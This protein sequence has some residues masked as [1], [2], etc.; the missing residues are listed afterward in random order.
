MLR[1]IIEKE[2]RDLAGSP[3]FILTFAVCATLIVLSFFIGAANY[4]ASVERYNAANA[5]NLR[6]YDG[7][8]DWLDVRD[9]R[10]FLAPQPLEALVA[11]ISNDIGRTTDVEARGELAAHGSRYNEEPILAVFRFLDLEF[12]FLIVLSLF[13]IL[14][15]YD[16]VSG[17]KERGTLRLVLSN[18]VPRSKY[19]LGKLLGSFGLLTVSLL[20]AIS[21]GCLLLPV[22]GVSLAAGDWIR[23][24]LIVLTGLLY[25]GAFLTA[26]IFVSSVTHRT[27]SSFMTML[28]VWIVSV[29]IIPRASVLLAGRAVEVPSVDELGAQKAAFGKDLWEEFRDDLSSYQGAKDEDIEVMMSHFNKFMDSLTVSRDEKMSVYAGRLD[30]QRYNRQV[31]QQRVAFN[32]ARVSPATSLSLATADLAGTSLKLKERYRAET[33]AFQKTFNDFLHEKT[34]RNIGGRMIIIRSDDEEE[35]KQPIDVGEIPVL[36]PQPS[37][38]SLAVQSA[39][40]DLGLLAIFNLIFFAAAFVSFGRYDA[41]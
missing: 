38:L 11:G 3:K 14:L 9:T 21:A 34:G 36:Q 41:R 1:V 7:I 6:R 8:T 23:L 16:A 4:N 5:E 19:I 22:M 39:A 30:E 17:E 2:I 27:S 40:V 20:I 28:V 12:I 32:L 15:G 24:G 26:S 29:M 10:I 13:A 35:D 18:P 33:I 31:Q 25:F 37:S